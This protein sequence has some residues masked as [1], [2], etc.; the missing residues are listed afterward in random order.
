MEE[1]KTQT[2]ETEEPK[3]T[4]PGKV[5]TQ[6]NLQRTGNV[7]FHIAIACVIVSALAILSSLLVP[8]VYGLVVILA[9]F[10]CLL[11][12]VFTFGLAFVQQDT[13]PAHDLLSSIWG[14]ITNS[15]ESMTLLPAAILSIVPYVSIV[16]IAVSCLSILMLCLGRAQGKTGKIVGVC[17][18]SVVC[19]A[20]LLVYYLVGAL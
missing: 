3:A 5:V 13:N 17:I 14:F 12:V 9:L 7:F 1:I 18:I 20:I 11:L 8:V 16:G 15:G 4:I 2:V 6:H 19:V 10:A